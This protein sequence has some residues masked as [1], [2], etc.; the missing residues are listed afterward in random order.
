M[1]SERKAVI[2]GI[3]GLKLTKGEKNLIRKKNQPWGIILFSRNIKNISQLK[4]LVCSIK[5]TASDNN[6]PI[7]IDQEGGLISRINKIMDFSLFSQSSFGD[8]YKKDKTK[9]FY[10][11]KIYIET[12]SNLLK[13]VGININTVPV[14]DVSRKKTH[15]IIGSR[16]YS[17]NCKIVKKIGLECIKHFSNNKIG[18]VI[19]HIPGHGLATVDSHKTLPIVKNKK[20]ELIKKDFVSFKNIRSHFAMTAH[21]MYKAYDNKFAAT[22]SKTIINKVIRK[23]IAFKG[24]LISDDIS[25]KA[26]PYDLIKNS[27]LAL[28]AG[29]NLILHCNGKISEMIKLAKIIPRIDNFTSKKTSQFYNFLR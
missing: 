24:L 11:Y 27:T 4:K 25:M 9:F 16:S 17:N 5:E 22:H 10:H 28:K 6:Y 23:H 21:V 15:K 29:C 20:E 26:L 19:K 13:E 12:I 14:L 8:L 7:L 1:N 3:K 18:T 2:F